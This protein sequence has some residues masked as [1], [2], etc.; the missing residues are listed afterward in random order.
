MSVVPLDINGILWC[1]AR[2]KPSFAP[3]S[4]ICVKLI[5]HKLRSEKIERNNDL[6]VK[7]VINQ[8]TS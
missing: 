6:S 4:K 2:Q 5:E 1:F 7:N 3:L 8:S